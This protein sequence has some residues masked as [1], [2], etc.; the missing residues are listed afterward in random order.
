[1][2]CSLNDVQLGPMDWIQVWIR[3]EVQM[4]SIFNSDSEQILGHG[5][6]RNGHSWIDIIRSM[7]RVYNRQAHSPTDAISELTWI[8]HVSQ[9]MTVYWPFIAGG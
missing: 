8:N 4:M 5:G 3:D 9:E 7:W 2:L 1:M 6:R